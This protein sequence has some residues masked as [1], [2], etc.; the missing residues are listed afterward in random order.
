MATSKRK[1]S[2]GGDEPGEREGGAPDAEGRTPDARAHR[3]SVGATGPHYV[4][5]DK[6]TGRIIGSYASLDATT[7]TFREV[8]EKT[9]RAMFPSLGLGKRGAKAA[10][11]ELSVAT[12]EAAGQAMDV[13]GM[14]VDAKGRLVPKPRLQLS[15]DR[16]AITGDGK[17]VAK[18]TVTAVD[19]N[20]ETDQHFAGE[21]RV[22]TT[23]GRLSER[24]G[25]VTLKKGV[26]QITLTS[27]PETIARVAL[28]ARDENHLAAIGAIDL[29]FL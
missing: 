23:H 11:T 1:A 15:A 29:E 28:T 18:I 22:M 13:S 25:V 9:V 27:T 19:A 7:G 16:T 6:A 8:D 14:R 26:G 3:S 12:L 24:G 4:L 2:N 17:D 5:Y 10:K 21:V 20:G